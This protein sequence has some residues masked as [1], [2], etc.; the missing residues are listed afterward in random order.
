[1]LAKYCDIVV[2]FIP[3]GESSSGTN[4]TLLEAKKN[5]KKTLII[6]WKIYIYI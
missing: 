6:S 3:D 5:G 2:G 1:M 4:Y